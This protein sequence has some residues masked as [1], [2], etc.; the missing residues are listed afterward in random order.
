MD[1][2]V[3]M[4][5][6]EC[7]FHF[8]FN[9]HWGNV[10]YPCRIFDEFSKDFLRKTSYCRI[11]QYIPICTYPNIYSIHPVQLV[12]HNLPDKGDLPLSKPWIHIFDAE[13]PSIW[14]FPWSWGYPFIARWFLFGG[15]S[16]RSEW[17]MF[18]GV[19]RHDLG[20][21]KWHKTF[22]SVDGMERASNLGWTPPC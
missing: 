4:G 20:S 8:K 18:L 15:K 7:E 16:Q 22:V 21:P 17:M 3:L 9:T 2:E 19:A 1:M 11:L 5:K 10:K 12:N 14:W 13:T 6:S